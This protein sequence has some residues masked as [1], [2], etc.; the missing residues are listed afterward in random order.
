MNVFIIKIVLTLLVV[1]AFSLPMF[2]PSLGSGFLEEIEVFGVGGT[3]GILSVFLLLV[4]FYCKDLQKILELVTPENRA[5]TPKSVWLMFLIP[6]NFIEDFFIVNNISKSIRCEAKINPA[7]SQLRH[8]G[9]YSG[10]GWCAAQIFSLAPGYIGKTASLFAIVLWV[11]HWRFIRNT[12]HLLE[13]A[14]NSMQP[15]DNASAD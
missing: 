3:L 8:F 5:S 4:Y 2:Y 9:F 10:I 12:N 1:A 6:Y 7:L 14:N 11:V 13:S 15:T